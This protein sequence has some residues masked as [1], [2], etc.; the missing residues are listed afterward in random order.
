MKKVL[1][2]II[3]PSDSLKCDSVPAPSCSI[4]EISKEKK[5]TEEKNTPLS[6]NH[7][8]INDGTIESYNDLL[9]IFSS[10][11]NVLEENKE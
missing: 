11:I 5:E 4:S 9:S 10:P 6:L 3:K 8:R 2:W 7:R 1:D